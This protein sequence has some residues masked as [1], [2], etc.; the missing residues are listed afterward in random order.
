MAT[1]HQGDV[2][3]TIPCQRS[4]GMSAISDDPAAR[5]DSGFYKRPQIGRIDRRDLLKPNSPNPFAAHFSGDHD[6]HLVLH[7]FSAFSDAAQ[8]RLIDFD[9]T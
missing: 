3:E 7:R 6:Y 2:S 1:E 9:V 5:R 8:E 4:I